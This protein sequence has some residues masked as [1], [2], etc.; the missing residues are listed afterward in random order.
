MED[1]SISA[2]PPGQSCVLGSDCDSQ[3]C[4]DGFCSSKSKKNQQC[5][6][7]NPLHTNQFPTCDTDL[8]CVMS[9][10]DPVKDWVCSDGSENSYCSGFYQ[11]TC[12]PGF[13][14]GVDKDNR[15]R[16]YANIFTVISRFFKNNGTSIAIIGIWTVIFVI[17]CVVL[18]QVKF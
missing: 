9:G 17:L 2:K 16:C 12:Q 6:M 15:S 10:S 7:P 11:G 13:W 5:I 18:S 14:C 1:T 4:V 8:T 3:M